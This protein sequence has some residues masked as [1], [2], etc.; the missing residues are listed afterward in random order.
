MLDGKGSV[1]AD[2]HF[3]QKVLVF[4]VIA[5]RVFSENSKHLCELGGVLSLPETQSMYCGPILKG[6]DGQ[7]ANTFDNFR[8]H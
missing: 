6:Y 4:D 5:S 3:A 7:K 2:L 1:V 8:C